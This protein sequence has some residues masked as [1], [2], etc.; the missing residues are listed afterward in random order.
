MR[1]IWLLG[2]TLMWIVCG[3]MALSL[4]MRIQ[5]ETPPKRL[6]FIAAAPVQA[7]KFE[8]LK[9]LAQAA[10]FQLDYRM[11]DGTSANPSLAELNGHDLLVIDAPYGA[12]LGAVQM[13]L[14][15]LLDNVQAPWIWLR[16]DGSRGRQLPEALVADLDLYYS[17][18]GVANFSGF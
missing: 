5:A 8:R 13:G 15:P 16:R 17:N 7:G 11:L 4:S 9:P 3:V 1:E 14:G 6:L 12:A 18:G 2:R 10:G